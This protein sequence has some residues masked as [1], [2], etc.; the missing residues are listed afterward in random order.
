MSDD[1][2]QVRGF[3]THKFGASID[4]CQDALAGVPSRGRYAVADGMTTA[5]HSRA[6]AQALVKSFVHADAGAKPGDWAQAAQ[7]LWAAHTSRLLADPATLD[8]TR[9]RLLMREASQATFL[10]LTLSADKS[11]GTWQATLLACGD[12]CAFHL[13]GERILAAF[14]QDQVEQFSATTNS[15]ASDARDLDARLRSANWHLA[16]GDTLLVATDALSKWLLRP[17]TTA[18]KRATLVG[19]VSGE[20]FAAFITAARMAAEGAA[21]LEDDDVALLNLPT[22]PTLPSGTDVFSPLEVDMPSQRMAPRVKPSGKDTVFPV[23]PPAPSIV[24]TG[25]GAVSHPEGTYSDTVSAATYAALEVKLKEAKQQT[26]AATASARRCSRNMAICA[27]AAILVVVCQAFFKDIRDA[28]GGNESQLSVATE[29]SRKPPKNT[30]TSDSMSEPLSSLQRQ[31]SQF[32]AQASAFGQ[33][34]R[35][36]SPPK[37]E[38]E[39]R[40]LAQELAAMQ[41]SADQ[42]PKIIND[43]K[44]KLLLAPASDRPAAPG[45]GST[46]ATPSAEAVEAHENMKPHKSKGSK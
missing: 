26:A 22:A 13:R 36:L 34:Y 39:K 4:E 23:R 45:G 2:S 5:V 6:W 17:E 10:G 25:Q 28:L 9:H 32:S 37:T 29:P 27:A 12:T 44:N 19:A 15:L 33:K 35:K 7:K 3:L 24:P 30:P 21:E 46:P 14:P 40:A 20:D 41:S 18:E 16:P 43:I 8:I 38:A 42:L 11:E 1:R 31:A